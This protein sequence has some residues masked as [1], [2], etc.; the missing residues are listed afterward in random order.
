MYACAEYRL[1]YLAQPRTA[2]RACVAFLKQNTRVRTIGSH[3]D[4]DIAEVRFRRRD[5][6]RI[7]TAVRNPWDIIVSWY[8]HNPYWLDRPQS[9]WTFPNFVRDFATGRRNPYVRPNRMYG[10]LQPE[11]TDIL[12]YET[13]W[14]DLSGVLG[15]PTPESERPRV[16]VSDRKP[17]REYYDDDTREFVCHQYER[18]IQDYGYEF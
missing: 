13:L 1:I 2:S 16:G 5:G 18:D 8:H 7:V 17:Y 10:I 12:R 9:D 14:D 15:I 3:H 11:A 6:W 4:M